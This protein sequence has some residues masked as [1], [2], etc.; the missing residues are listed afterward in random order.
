ME[1][2]VKAEMKQGDVVIYG[3]GSNRDQ[4]PKIIP[5]DCHYGGACGLNG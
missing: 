1:Y 5:S 2:A 3:A 4:M